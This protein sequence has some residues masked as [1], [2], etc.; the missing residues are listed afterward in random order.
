MRRLDLLCAATIAA[1]VFALAGC[2]TA[3]AP[4]GP[5]SVGNE[6]FPQ[7]ATSAEL[8]G[9]ATVLQEGD[10]DPRLC[11]GAL[12]ASYPPQCSG[13]VVRNWDWDTAQ[14]AETASG[15]TWGA[16]AVF[17]T[18]DGSE[19]TST[20]DP[21]P[22]SLYDRM[23]DI[24]PRRDENNKGATS[25]GELARVQS[26]L[27][28]SND[29]FIVST[30]TENGYLWLSVMYDDGSVQAYLDEKYGPEVVAVVSALRPA[31]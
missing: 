2:A 10:D 12:A 14:Q 11:L 29:E 23:A 9:E 8:V 17:G 13:P 28:A 7:P 3:Q 24:D 19:F 26:D 16:Y 6:A 27:T 20:R 1:G 22:L 25:E 4:G 5:P 21:I 31:G 18:W 15:V 30:L